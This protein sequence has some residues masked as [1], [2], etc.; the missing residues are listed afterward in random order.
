MLP[1]RLGELRKMR[2]AREDIHHYYSILYRLASAGTRASWDAAENF[3]IRGYKKVRTCAFPGVEIQ[4]SKTSLTGKAEMT[5]DERVIFLIKALIAEEPRYGGMKIPPGEAERKTLLRSLMNV[6]P[7]RPAG[8]DFLAVQDAYL[9]EEIAKKG[10]T[11]IADLSHTE[12]GIYLWQGDITTLRCGAVVNAANSGMTGCYVPC[13]G[14]IDNEIHTYA[15]VE[16]RLACAELMEKQGHEE[17]TG[18]AKLTPAYELPCGYVIHTVGPIIYGGVTQ[19][20]RELLASCYR[21]CLKLARE[22]GIG[23]I[24]FPCIS[25]GEFH[26][27]NE[28][29]ARIAVDTVRKYRGEV[30]VIFNVFKDIDLGIYRELLG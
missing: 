13:H 20:D 24:A 30:E 10:I 6:R 3:F 17:P 28:E 29:A 5:Q 7:P 12:P 15:G 9:R 22:N 16:L 8:R 4:L 23:S 2:S 21:S 19:R 18:T 11:D 27:P 26:F 25:T 1:P 14:C